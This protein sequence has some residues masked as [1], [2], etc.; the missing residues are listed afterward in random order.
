MNQD[1]PT[2]ALTGSYRKA[3]LC[4][5]RLSPANLGTTLEVGRIHRGF[6]RQPTQELLEQILD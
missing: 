6:A 1:G 3:S 4:T 2:E 5:A